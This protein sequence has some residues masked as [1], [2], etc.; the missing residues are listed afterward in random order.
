MISGFV[1]ILAMI[2]L[3]AIYLIIRTRRVEELVVEKTILSETDALTSPLN[4]RSSLEMMRNLWEINPGKGAP[5]PLIIIDVD[6]F[7]GYDGTCGHL[8]GD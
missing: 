4:R 6:Y 7:K 5:M 3:F 2:G 1:A 8:A